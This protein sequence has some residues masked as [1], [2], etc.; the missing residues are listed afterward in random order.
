MSSFFIKAGYDGWRKQIVNLG[1]LKND[2][3]KEG[4]VTVYNNNNV[5]LNFSNSMKLKPDVNNSIEIIKYNHNYALVFNNMI[6][7]DSPKLFTYDVNLF[8]PIKNINYVN[9]NIFNYIKYDMIELSNVANFDKLR[10]LN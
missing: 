10:T 3:W 1:L 4:I 8:F 7:Y 9:E 2:F 5:K 6:V